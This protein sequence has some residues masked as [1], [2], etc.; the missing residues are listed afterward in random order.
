[1]FFGI[2][3]QLFL[4]LCFLL[5]QINYVVKAKEINPEITSE[6]KNNLFIS[7]WKPLQ[8]ENEKKEKANE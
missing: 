6:Y 2:F 4:I 1:M 7:G 5:I 3:K 8:E